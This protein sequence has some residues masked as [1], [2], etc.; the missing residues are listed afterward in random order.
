M[1]DDLNALS[2]EEFRTEWRGWLE[3]NY[4]EEWRRPI[5]LRLRGQQER[6]WL[7]M[8]Y[9]AGWRAPAW[10]K[11]HGGLGLSFAKQLIYHQ[12]LEAFGAARF[13]DSG[14]VLLGPILIKYGTKAQQETYLP[15]ILDGSELWCQGY[16]E[17]NAGS[18][19][20]SLKTTAIPDG[21]EF[22]V[23]GSKIWTTMVKE[24]VRMFLLVRTNKE[25]RKQAG[26]SFLLMDMDT[27]GVTV[28]P[29]MNLAGEDEFGE[30]FFENARIP[31][32][33]LVH[34]LDQGWTVAKT[35][36]GAERFSNGAPTLPGQAFDILEDLVAG[37]G[38]EDDAGLADRLAQHFCDLNDLAALYGEVADAA[39]RGDDPGAALNVL[40][41]VSS[42]LF[43][44]I[45]DEIMTV[46]GEDA[47]TAPP[48]HVAGVDADL[49]K[50]FMI[51]RPTTIYAGANEVQRDMIA[52]AL[53]GKPSR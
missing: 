34:E 40:K 26:I 36:L 53:L 38:L 35:L 7:R 1:A 49:H 21:D 17:P 19:L 16:S 32:A 25:G 4:P 28:R 20:A 22:I 39:I 42:E 51:A 50:I 33:N 18:D 43:Q 9:E 24:A 45:S 14:G 5:T 27:A 12:E 6:D 29:I 15:R 31:K 23:N 30:V 41:V 13:L 11:E 2:D 47:G 44:R 37:L 46:A 48:S 10:P 52:R 3:A 8:L